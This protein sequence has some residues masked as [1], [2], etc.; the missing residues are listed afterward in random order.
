MVPHRTFP[1]DC[2]ACHVVERWNEIKEEVV[3][4]HGKET[5]RVL[6]GAH[7]QAA[8]LRCHNDRGPVRGYVERGCGGCH[9]DPHR[10]ALGMT[11]E[12]CHGQ[13]TWEPRG[14]VAD[15][16]RTRFPLTGAH[17]FA[18]CESCH[19][20]ATVGDYRG[21]PAACEACHQEEAGRAFP[22]HRV[23]G[24]VRD[25][26]RCHTPAGWTA[27]GFDHS[28][29]PLADGHAGADC[30]SCHAGG[31]FAGTSADCHACHR[32][33]YLGAPGHVAEGRSTRCLD[34]HRATTWQDVTG[35]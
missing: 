29:F 25:C 12:E 27:P 26:E 33:D 14:L 15:H 19:A 5:G 11:C 1:M 2:G 30:L 20:R 13:A 34:C 23:N 7:E 3:F 32:T 24:W 18:Q 8:C 31:R 10:G 9:V 17:A 6:E 16:A 35:N 22:P 21:T 28:A 4:D